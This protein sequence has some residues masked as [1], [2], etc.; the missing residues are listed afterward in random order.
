MPTVKLSITLQ[1]SLMPEL[2]ARGE[3]RSEILSRD[4]L[5]YYEALR[6]ARRRLRDQLSDGEVGLILDALNGCWL[7]DAHTVGLIW[8]EAED[9]IRLNRADQK[10]SVDGP[11]LVRKLRA[12]SYAELCAL[13]DA[14]ERWWHRVSDD[15]G[16]AISQAL[17]P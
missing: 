13:T 16:P 14:A 11:D 17:N 3:T 1:D 12:M 7:Q 15:Q 6:D 5:R 10:W 4:L 9:A 2:D 8:A